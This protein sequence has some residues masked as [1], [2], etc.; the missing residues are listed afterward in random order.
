MQQKKTSEVITA[1]LPYVTNDFRVMICQEEDFSIEGKQLLD[2]NIRQLK[3]DVDETNTNATDWATTNSRLSMTLMGKLTRIPNLKN[4]DSRQK[5]HR[6]VLN[7]YLGGQ[8]ILDA[9]REYPEIYDKVISTAAHQENFLAMNCVSESAPG[10]ILT[11]TVDTLK[12]EFDEQVR[13]LHTCNARSL[14]YGTI[15]DWLLRCPLD[16]P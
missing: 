14:A 1:N 2:A 10:E 5:F 6:A 7:W 8:S 12:K 16:F 3:I 4:E 9:L 13:E 15:A 11:S